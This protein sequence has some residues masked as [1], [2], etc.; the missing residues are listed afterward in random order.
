MLCGSHVKIW[1]LAN[2]RNKKWNKEHQTLSFQFFINKSS[3]LMFFVLFFHVVWN[4]SNFD[5][6][7]EK[8]LAQASCTE[9]T[10]PLNKLPWRW[11]KVV[12][13]LVDHWRADSWKRSM[14]LLRKG[15]HP[16]TFLLMNSYLMDTK[17]PVVLKKCL[18]V[19][20]GHTLWALASLIHWTNSIR[21]C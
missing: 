2:H 20:N 3:I 12:H 17:M 10:L 9:L 21:L 13:L 4:I 14:L 8:Q 18:L 7:T 1:N 11:Q 16:M 19:R 5:M 15:L 6:W